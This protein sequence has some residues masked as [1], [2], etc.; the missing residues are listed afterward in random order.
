MGT[1]IA[2]TEAERIGLLS[3]FGV[4]VTAGASLTAAIIAHRAKQ[5]NSA[6]HGEVNNQ[7]TKLAGSVETAA[8][9]IDSLRGDVADVKEDVH[10]LAKR[11][12]HAHERID[13]Q[14]WLR[15]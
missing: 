10:T 5:S 2:V 6:Q 12:D 15:P 13:H 7:L 4:V 11:V 1:M 14:S 9:K 3:F 8:Q